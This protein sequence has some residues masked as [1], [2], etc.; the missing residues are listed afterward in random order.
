MYVRE[1]SAAYV[2]GGSTPQ[3]NMIPKQD[4]ETG[5]KVAQFF[6]SDTAAS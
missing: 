4:S 5:P 3:D 2:Y 1:A 6:D